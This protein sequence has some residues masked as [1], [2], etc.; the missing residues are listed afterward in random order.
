MNIGFTS[1]NSP[2]VPEVPTTAEIVAS[3]SGAQKLSILNG[4]AKKILASRL[5]YEI[6]VSVGVIRHL[7]R[8]IDEIEIKAR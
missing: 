7:Y 8:K 1:Y 3:L 4:F 2:P 6:D 5:K